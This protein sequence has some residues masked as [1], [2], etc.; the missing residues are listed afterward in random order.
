MRGDS[1]FYLGPDP[2][3]A[4]G[5]GLAVVAREDCG[6]RPGDSELHIF[7]TPTRSG[8]SLLELPRV[9]ELL[10][11][12]AK[13]AIMWTGSAPAERRLRELGV[14]AANSPAQVARRLENKAHFSRAAAAAGLP[15]PPT[16]TGVAGPELA[17]AA[18]SLGLPLVFQL[19]RGYSG[20]ATYPVSDEAEVV[21]LCTEFA[22]HPG[23]VSRLV[24]GHPVT[25][26]G[27]ALPD[28]VVVGPACRQLTGIPELTPHPLGS[29]GND[30]SAAVPEPELVREVSVR[31]AEWL[32][33]EGHLGVF[34]VDLVVEEGGAAWCIE[35]NPRLVASVPLWSL[36]A[37]DAGPSLLQLHLAAFGLAD[38]QP[39]PLQCHWSQLILYQLEDE[40]PAPR[41]AT[42]HGVV[43][44]DGE[45]L[46][47]GPL[48]LQG[49]PPGG[50]A[51]VV[52]RPSGQGR[53]LARLLTEGPITAA[54]GSL[55]PSLQGFVRRLR[56]GPEG[57]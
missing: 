57:A 21:R 29:C 32:R 24:K 50:A 47:R 56:E 28:R 53:E 2:L 9:Q 37:R 25:V 3:P 51:L 36:S 12:R 42:G 39:G 14:R 34:G 5:T 44:P 6:L 4:L 8:R 54:D 31:A 33:R 7:P 20:A 13:G 26:S 40:V 1:V 55:L 52:R 35:V 49:P 19:A 30:F 22:G 41:I 17:R 23:R 27:V 45:F 18:L 10:A 38:D 43:A 46:A 15:V 16:V 11:A 48:D